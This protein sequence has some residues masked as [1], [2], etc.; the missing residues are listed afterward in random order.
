[1]TRTV[2][3]VMVVLGVALGGTVALIKRGEGHTQPQQEA[4]RAVLVPT[5]V[6]RRVIVPPCGTG[7]PVTSE[8]AGALARTPGSIV[9]VLQRDRGLR[10]VLVPRCQA[11]QGAAPSE[12]AQLPS[13][14]F[15]LPVGANITAGRGG[16]AEAGTELVQSQLTVPG[17]STIRTVVVPRCIER[18]EQAK[19]TV[20]GRAVI[21]VPR[22]SK[23]TALA[24]PC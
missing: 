22:Q 23:T 12:G 19:K 13:A 16:S 14:A 18:R 8:N 7:V 21:L 11:S 4:A 2:W 10:I 3:V 9:F 1:M 15:L 17:N 6:A 5:E 20:S 24:P